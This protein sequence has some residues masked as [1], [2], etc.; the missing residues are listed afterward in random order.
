MPIP[1]ESAWRFTVS[2][3][4][5]SVGSLGLS[6]TC[7]PT[8]RLADHLDIASEINEPAKPITA[9]I[10]SSAV[11]L[12]PPVSSS[13]RSTPSR[14]SVMLITNTTARLVIMNKKIRFMRLPPSSRN[15]GAQFNTAHHLLCY[16]GHIPVF[17]SAP[18]EEQTKK[19]FSLLPCALCLVPCALCLVP[20]ASYH[21]IEDYIFEDRVSAS[22]RS[23]YARRGGQSPPHGKTPNS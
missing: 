7:A 21:T 20:C 23:G 19:K 3:S 12:M 13:Q 17:S 16:V 9:D 11:K 14:R 8:I 5:R 15:Y 4:Q 6:M 18:L 10:T 22:R 2:T 1:A